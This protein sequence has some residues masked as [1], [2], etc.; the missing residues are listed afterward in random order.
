VNAGKGSSAIEL[1]ARQ[2]SIL[3]ALARPEAKNQLLSF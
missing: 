1:Q 3:G 2:G